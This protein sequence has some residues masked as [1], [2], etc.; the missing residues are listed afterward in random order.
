MTSFGWESLV[1]VHFSCHTGGRNSETAIYGLQRLKIVVVCGIVGVK[2]LKTNKKGK[3]HGDFDLRD[4]TVLQSL[5]YLQ[6]TTGTPRKRR[7]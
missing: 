2:N 6:N 4:N 7:Q 1:P 3:Y 5:T